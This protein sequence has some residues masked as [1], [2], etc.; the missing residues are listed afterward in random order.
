MLARLTF[1]GIV[2]FWL[3]MN[4]FLWRAEFGSHAGD[5][6]VPF[7][8]VWHKILTAPDASSLSVYQHGERMGYAEFSTSVGQQLAA[9]EEDKLPS[10]ELVK[11]AG[12]QVHL[13][14]NV[15]FGEFTNRLK[16]DSRVQFTGTRQWQEFNLKLTS[17]TSVLELHSLA[18]NQTVHIRISGENLNVERELTFAELQNPNAIVRIFAGNFADTLLGVVD[19]PALAPAS[20]TQKIS[21]EARRT[22]A[23][24]G[25]EFVPVYRL[26]SSALGYTVAVD[27]STLG[28]ILRV[29]LPGGYNAHIDEW[30]KQP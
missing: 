12:Y 17:R 4:F 16:F 24:I 29:E 20:S 2:G 28:E 30:S 21:W 15:A 1:F 11:R 14:G 23:K 18:T 9:L 8:L 27:V 25:H 26:E 6:P 3:T 19:L 7:E 5:I 22:R 10:E 13:A